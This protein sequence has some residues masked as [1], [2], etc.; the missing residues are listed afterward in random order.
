MEQWTDHFKQLLVS[1]DTPDTTDLP[2]PDPADVDDMTR[3]ILDSPIT[4]DELL[5]AIKALKCGKSAGAD[6]LISEI[7]FRYLST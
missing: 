3:S 5:T 2:V 4:Q 6:L 1:C 7:C